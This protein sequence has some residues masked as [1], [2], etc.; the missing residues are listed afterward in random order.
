MTTPAPPP[1]TNSTQVGGTWWVMD[2]IG[3]K[4]GSNNYAIV[5]SA[6][7][8]N[9]GPGQ[10]VAAGPFQTKAQAQA[11]ITQQGTG[12]FPTPPNPL[13]FLGWLQEAGHYVGLLV[14]ALLDVHLYIS[15]GWLLLG[16]SL[17]L[18]GI[19][20]WIMSTREAQN[21]G[22]LIGAVAA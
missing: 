3:P 1:A 11:W 10:Q 8:P 2:I 14:S 19:I 18:G 16:F 22:G 4:G 21:V 12:A 7:R 13:A 6:N 15:L 5:Q 17:L 20:L 9:P